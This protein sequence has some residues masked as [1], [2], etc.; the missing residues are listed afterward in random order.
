MMAIIKSI[1]TH[2]FVMIVTL[3]S[4]MILPNTVPLQASESLPGAPKFSNASMR[5]QITAYRNKSKSI[6]KDQ[7]TPLVEKTEKGLD[8]LSTQ[9]VA[10]CNKAITALAELKK[11]EAIP[12]T[13]NK[14]YTDEQKAWLNI[15]TIG[16]EMLDFHY[17]MAS[18]QKEIEQ[19]IKDSIAFQK[20]FSDKVSKANDRAGKIDTALGKINAAS[21]NFKAI[22]GHFKDLAGYIG[23]L[24]GES[25]IVSR[26]INSHRHLKFSFIK[27]KDLTGPYRDKL[28]KLKSKKLDPDATGFFYG[29]EKSWEETMLK[30]YTRYVATIGKWKK[31][32]RVLLNKDELLDFI[33]DKSGTLVDV[34]GQHILNVPM[35]PTSSLT[36]PEKLG[37][38]I[39]EM[40]ET[41]TK[42]GNIAI[43]MEWYRID[44]KILDAEEE[45]REL[46]AVFQREINA[47]ETEASTQAATVEE[48]HEV[49]IE[50]LNL[51]S[52][53]ANEALEKAGKDKQQ[54][55]TSLAELDRIRGKIA[56][57]KKLVQREKHYW[58]VEWYNE[59]EQIA[60]EKLAGNIKKVDARIKKFNGERPK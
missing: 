39:L 43:G 31:A 26:I 42:A 41:L 2:H 3:V 50:R 52:A 32:N 10:S 59:Q 17:K 21:D 23:I 51:E 58:L 44:Q 33:L 53:Q 48:K 19:D 37:D 20:L 12:E 28:A 18:T 56:A 45:R 27:E 34:A 22:K 9:W 54:E 29:Y 11:S 38:W 14:W 25:M 60:Y 4:A 6:L 46:N 57:E 16:S 49:V 5:Q 47:A 35:P 1:S 30:T 15:R 24:H 13:L 7:L 55:R 8:S 36:D 40:R